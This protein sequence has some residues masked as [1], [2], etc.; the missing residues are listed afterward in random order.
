MPSTPPDRRPSL[1]SPRDKLIGILLLIVVVFFAVQWWQGRQSSGP[2][3]PGMAPATVVSEAPAKDG[4]AE[5][6]V[7]Y[8]VDG[9]SRTVTKSVDAQAFSTQGK[10]AWVCYK[11]GNVTDASIRLPQDPLCGQN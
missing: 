7:R 11:P 9:Q 10:V 3:R 8:S 1:G 5:L 2:T 4:L 6:T